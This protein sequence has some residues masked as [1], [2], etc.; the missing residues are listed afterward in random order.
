MGRASCDGGEV[1]FTSKRWSVAYLPPGHRQTGRQVDWQGRRPSRLGRR[2][3]CVLVAVLQCFKRI[4]MPQNRPVRADSATGVF[5]FG[6][7]PHI[8]MGTNKNSL[9]QSDEKM[10]KSEVFSRAVDN[11]SVDTHAL[12]NTSAYSISHDAGRSG[13]VH[14]TGTFVRDRHLSRPTVRSSTLAPFG[15]QGA[16]LRR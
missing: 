9:L 15:L 8:W 5:A 13:L 7:C 6:A 14:E 12:S 2:T 10:L 1:G 3:Y 4:R 16:H 11:A